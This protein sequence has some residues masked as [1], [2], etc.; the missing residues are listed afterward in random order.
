MKPQGAAFQAA[1]VPTATIR[2]FLAKA[3]VTPVMGRM[4]VDDAKASV[5][6]VICVRK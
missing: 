1:L 3:N 4:S 5:A 6:R 2:A